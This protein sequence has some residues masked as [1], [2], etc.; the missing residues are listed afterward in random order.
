[1]FKW[2]KKGQ[3]FS[4]KKNFPWMFSHAQCPFPLEFDNFIRVYFAT[5]EDYKG[6]MCRAYGGFVD[7]D[8]STFKVINISSQPLMGLGGIGEFDEFGSMPISV[9]R[10]KGEY[11]LYY[12]GWTRHFSVPYDWEIGFA[13]SVDGERFEKVG[14]G[15]LLGP[16]LNEPYLNSTPVVYKFDDDNWHMFYH[17]GVR[18]IKEGDK[19]ESQ[20][21]IK[22][23]TSNN[24]LD[25]NRN[26]VQVI[27]F[28][29]ENE[30]QT[31]PAIMKLGDRYHM[32]FCY[33][34][35]LDF[36]AEKDKSYRIGYAY[37][38]DL[39]TWIRD[40]SKAGIDVS[41]TGW[42]S[43]MI[44]YPHVLEINGKHIMFYCGNHFGKEGFGYAEL[45]I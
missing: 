18:W 38:D 16:A 29:V 39:F 3:I 43:Q 10:H 34:Y 24:G 4:P 25:W 1:M 35:G 45:E 12:V 14:K 37:S 9:V 22:H 36:R 6:G 32:F 20:Y 44:E 11:Y 27:P 17:T 8:K 21:V 42:D 33:R 2:T 26:D 40:D 41:E 15:P 23:A 28:K 30:C 19:L 31:T 13:K 7:L 5:R